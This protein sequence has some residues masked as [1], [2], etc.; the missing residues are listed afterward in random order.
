[1]KKKDPAQPLITDKR[2]AKLEIFAHAYVANGGV[3]TEAAVAAGYSE[4]TSAVEACQM[5][6]LPIV[7]ERIAE[8]RRAL[9]AKHDITAESVLRQ[10]SAIVH[11]DV[12]KLVNP[13][14]SLRNLHDL[15]DATAAAIQGVD[16]YVEKS[17]HEDGSEVTDNAATVK[18][19]VADKNTAIANAMKHLGLL[20]DG[21]VN[22]NVGAVIITNDDN[23]IGLG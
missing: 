20:K 2:K 18:Y 1:M 3:G 23:G 10:L 19:K 13:D 21:G 15:D 22:V 11:F 16:V 7:Q 9:I 8:L 5:L 17:Q 4:R 12:R 14:G 6:K